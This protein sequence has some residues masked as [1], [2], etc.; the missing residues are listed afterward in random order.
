M[1]KLPLNITKQIDYT[2]VRIINLPLKLIIIKYYRSTDI[3]NT[4]IGI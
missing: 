3:I 4:F 1:G 2:N